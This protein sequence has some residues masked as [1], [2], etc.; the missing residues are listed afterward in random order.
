MSGQDSPRDRRNRGFDDREQ[1]SP[2]VEVP[3]PDVSP[4]NMSPVEMSPVE[5]SETEPDTVSMPA[6]PRREPDRND[7]PGSDRTADRAGDQRFSAVPFDQPTI[8]LPRTGIRAALERLE[9]EEHA[10]RRAAPGPDET[11]TEPTGTTENA[12]SSGRA[13]DASASL[14]RASGVMAIGTL[15]SRVTGF[16]R[17]VAL[18]VAIGTAVIGD[19]YNVANTTPNILYDLLLGGVLTSVVVP[20]LARAAREDEDGGDAFAS[21]LLTLV[22]LFT[23]GRTSG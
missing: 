11:P 3:R 23:R 21:S 19:A 6:L 13:P 9:A 1:E 14:G 16:M 22:V 4:A 7:D 10:A 18:A 12:A 8:A 17:T 15:A 5:M 2:T 20:V